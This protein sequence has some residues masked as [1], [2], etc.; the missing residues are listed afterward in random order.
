[1]GIIV[2]GFILLTPLIGASQPY[3]GATNLQQILVGQYP[4]APATADGTD[5]VG[6]GAVL[7]L[8]KDN[9]VMSEVKGITKQ[10]NGQPVT[11]VPVSNTYANGAIKQT[12]LSGFLA[13]MS[14]SGPG[15]D[16]QTFKRRFMTGEKFFV[17]QIQS[18]TDGVVFTLLSDPING[19]RYH[20]TLTFPIAK[21]PDPPPEQVLATVAEVLRNDA[22]QS[23]PAAIPTAQN[24]SSPADA[25]PAQPKTISIGQSK[26]QVQALFGPPTRVAQL[27]SKEID[28]YPDMKVTFVNNKVT[29]IDAD[30]Q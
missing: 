3:G 7:V 28:F 27:G 30:T 10:I 19:Q 9:L 4:P 23:S 26:S 24:N 25:T 17:I 16:T 14:L 21:D 29:D 6:P 18:A 20:A 13:K 12:G 5:L 8:Q 1:M 15:G 11:T 22:D 2:T